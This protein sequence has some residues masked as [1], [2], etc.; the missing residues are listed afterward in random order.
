MSWPRRCSYPG[1]GRLGRTVLY[2]WAGLCVGRYCA[3]HVRAYAEM[4]ADQPIETVDDD[5]D[6]AEPE[7]EDD[8]Q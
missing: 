7:D 4:M 3:E 5:S 6:D 2:V 1:C 8:R